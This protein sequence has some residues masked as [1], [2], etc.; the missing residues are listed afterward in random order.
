[1]N[2]TTIHITTTNSVSGNELLCAR[3]RVTEKNDGPRVAKLT[4]RTVV[5]TYQ[6]VL[7]VLYDKSLLVLVVSY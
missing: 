3:G 4:I 6:Q 2:T 1:M 5:S 7:I